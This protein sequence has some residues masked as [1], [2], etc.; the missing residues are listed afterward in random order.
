MQCL[1]FRQLKLTDPYV[2]DQ[3]ANEHR[4]VCAACRAFEREIRDL[5]ATTKEALSVDVPEGFAAKILLNQALQPQ[6]RR[7]TRST[8]LSMAASFFALA[9]GS[10][11]YLQL[12]HAP[13]EVSVLEHIEHEQV[14][15]D[16]KLE[17]A[18]IQQVMYSV[19]AES[20]AL[21]GEIIYA[22]NCIIDGELVAHLVVRDED[23]ELTLV[24]IP[25][26]PIN[27]AIAIE[28]GDWHGV[29]QPHATGSM[30]ILSRSELANIQG[31]A[32]QYGRAI[33]KRTI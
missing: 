3:D 7:P 15:T 25:H 16:R 4:D 1:E 5:D 6:P 22:S 28:T 30:A 24:L 14:I 31:T 9:V 10:I 12:S 13:M 32:A 21:P 17:P 11:A 20:S 8:W 33:R 26:N 2:N 27:G 18:H 29:I 23:R 19:D